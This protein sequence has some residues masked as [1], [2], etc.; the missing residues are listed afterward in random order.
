LDSWDVGMIILV[1]LVVVVVVVVY[2]YI[3]FSF[4]FVP[5]VVPHQLIQIAAKVEEVCPYNIETLYPGYEIRV[6]E[7]TPS[8][9]RLM[10]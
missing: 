8:T 10:T 5:L 4:Q 9:I 3:I 1:V 6:R 7:Q 2:E